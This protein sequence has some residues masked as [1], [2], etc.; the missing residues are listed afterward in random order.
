VAHEPGV[1]S[2]VAAADVGLIVPVTELDDGGVGMDPISLIV[3]ALAAGAA[4][5]LKDAATSAVKDAYARLRD[6]VRGRVAGRHIAETALAEYDKAPEVWVAPLSAQL[7]EVGAH[8]DVKIIEAAQR[9]M[10][11][12]DEVGTTAGKYLVDVRGAQG[13]QVGDR[14]TQTNTFTNLPIT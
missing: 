7:V 6:L 9:V 2:C 12:V 1:N 11:L 14:N 3:D 4:S 8:T 10:A 13:V 5:G